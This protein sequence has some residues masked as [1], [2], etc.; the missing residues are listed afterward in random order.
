MS[1]EIVGYEV[2]EKG[3]LLVLDSEQFTR[4]A[5]I[6]KSKTRNKKLKWVRIAKSNG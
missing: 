5:S 3:G 4:E 2:N 6:M 1:S